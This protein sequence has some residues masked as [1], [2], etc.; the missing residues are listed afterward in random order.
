MF[1]TIANKLFTGV[2]AF[3]MMFFSSYKGNDAKFKNLDVLLTGP[4]LI[5]RTELQDAFTNDFQEVF[6]SGKEIRVWFKIVVMAE[7]KTILQN[8]FFH[9][10]QFDPLSQSFTLFIEETQATY[11]IEDYNELIRTISIVNYFYDLPDTYRH[12]KLTVEL[13]SFLKKITLANLDKQVD[14]MMLWNYKTPFSSKEI[15]GHETGL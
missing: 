15:S 6:K 5:I 9:E 12:Q 14:L 3:A 8:E 10:I 1:E 7:K 11:E 2:V 13:S 4:Q